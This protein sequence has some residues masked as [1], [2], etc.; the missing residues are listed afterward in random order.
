MHKIVSHSTC[1]IR[2]CTQVKFSCIV[3]IVLARYGIGTNGSILEASLLAVHFDFNAVLCTIQVG[4][5]I[6]CLFSII[7][8][9]NPTSTFQYRSLQIFRLFA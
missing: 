1:S 2:R 4:V 9:F 7:Q 5:Y 6:F 3:F 8:V